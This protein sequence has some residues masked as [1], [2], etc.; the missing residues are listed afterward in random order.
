MANIEYYWISNKGD[1]VND[2]VQNA[3]NEYEKYVH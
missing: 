1:V 2:E 3:S